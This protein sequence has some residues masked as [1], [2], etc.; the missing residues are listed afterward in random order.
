MCSD[1]S[2]AL[3]QHA[4]ANIEAMRILDLS[5][6]CAACIHVRDLYSSHILI[7]MAGYYYWCIECLFTDVHA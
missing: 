1:I 6:V 3:E 2:V 5:G 7:A 4:Y